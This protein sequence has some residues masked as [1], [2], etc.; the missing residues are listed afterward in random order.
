MTENSEILSKLIKYQRIDIQLDKKLAFNDLNRISYNL[1]FD[2][3]TDECC[4]WKGYITNLKSKTKNCYISFFFKNKK[5]SLHR[6]LF[7][8]YIED[9]HDNEYIKYTCCNKG[10]CCTIGHMKKVINEEHANDHHVDQ[11]VDLNINST[12]INQEKKSN[13]IQVSF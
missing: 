11:P 12:E 4:I 6:L 7:A 9:I 2:I 1:P 8:N 13:K 10:K 3:F 5:V